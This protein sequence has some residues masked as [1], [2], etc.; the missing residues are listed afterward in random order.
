MSRHG[1]R[2]NAQRW[3]CPVCGTTKPG[4]GA[5]KGLRGGGKK[6]KAISAGVVADKTN[7]DI[8]SQLSLP[9]ETVRD[10]LT[11]IRA[12]AEVQNA[13]LPPGPGA[14]WLWVPLPAPFDSGVIAVG[15]GRSRGPNSKTKWRVLGWRQGKTLAG[16]RSLRRLLKRSGRPSGPFPRNGRGNQR[17]EVQAWLAATLAPATTVDEAETRLWVLMARANSWDLDASF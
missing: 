10:R 4:R 3:R 6:L 13:A 2:G 9:V 5:S 17:A 8:A 15:L 11:K 1:V 14:G 12:A 16:V 7:E